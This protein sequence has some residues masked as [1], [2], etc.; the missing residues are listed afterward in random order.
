MGLLN[1]IYSNFRNVYH[2]RNLNGQNTYIE[3]VQDCSW[4]SNENLLKITQTNPI[5]NATML[6][7]SRLFASGKFSVVD[8]N[9]NVKEGHYLS[10]LIKNPNPYQTSENFLEEYIWFLR[11]FGYDYIFPKGPDGMNPSALYN[12]K[13]SL[14]EYPSNFKTGFVFGD[15]KINAPFIYDRDNQNLTLNAGDVVKYFDIPNGIC[16]ENMLISTSRLMA[17][18]KPI[19]T[20]DI[21]YNAKS[22]AIRSNG[23]ELYTIKQNSAHAQPFTEEEKQEI[24]V[25]LNSNYG[26]NLGR[27]RALITGQDLEHKSLHIALNELGLDESIIKDAEKI[28]IGLGIPIDVIK[29]DPK[30][31][32][33]DNQKQAEIKF[34]QNTIQVEADSFAN[35]LTDMFLKDTGLRLVA[36]YDHLPVMQDQIHKKFEVTSMQAQA[37]KDLIDIGVDTEDAFNEVELDVEIQETNEEIQSTNETE[38]QTEG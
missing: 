32:T 6:Y 21:A 18:S 17:I 36:S 15:E 13:A 4:G 9:G 26:L 16:S 10:E 22:I 8:S 37:A 31:S 27:S 33:F 2:E 38:E 24:Q 28:V 19:E 12:L 5:V 14:I 23:K 30:K 34:I 20:V 25:R 29:Y 3:K 7:I 35:G 11:T 1:R